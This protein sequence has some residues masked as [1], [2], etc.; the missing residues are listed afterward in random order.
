MYLIV[1]D[2]V[3]TYF[4]IRRFRNEKSRQVPECVPQLLLGLLLGIHRSAIGHFFC[5]S[6][7]KVIKKLTAITVDEDPTGC[8]RWMSRKEI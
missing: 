8:Q 4:I 3:S 7:V 5:L 6:L 1:H 2:A